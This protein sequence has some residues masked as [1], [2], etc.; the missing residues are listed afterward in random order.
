M[1]IPN[2]DKIADHLDLLV[3]K[4]VPAIVKEY[5][6]AHDYSFGRRDRV[7]TPEEREVST[8]VGKVKRT[9]DPTGEVVLEQESLRNTLRRIGKRVDRLVKD[10]QSIEGVLADVFED[11]NAYEPLRNMQIADT[12]SR[13]QHRAAKEAQRRRELQEEI[14]RH[15]R[16]ISSLRRELRE[17]AA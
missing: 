13:E 9:S 8:Q 12:A 17:G 2:P 4:V 15:E 5:R 14:N 16:A 1:S 7:V 3:A 6:H 11:P 10:A